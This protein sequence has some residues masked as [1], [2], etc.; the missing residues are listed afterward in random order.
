MRVSA[1]LV[2]ILEASCFG[3][4]VLPSSGTAQQPLIVQGSQPTTLDS[5][6]NVHRYVIVGDSVPGTLN[7]QGG[8]TELIS[9]GPVQF[10]QLPGNVYVGRGAL[11]I[12]NFSGG[13][14]RTGTNGDGETGSIF[15]GDRRGSFG[16]SGEGI[17]NIEPSGPGTVI[18]GGN[19]GTGGSGGAGTGTTGD[20]AGQ[21][22]AF[23][24]HVGN[25]G[26]G[27]VNLSGTAEA[28]NVFIGRASHL[29]TGEFAEGDR[30]VVNVS[31]A[32][33]RLGPRDADTST[34]NIENGY[35]EL[36]VE[37]SGQVNA[38]TLSISGS[39]PDGGI[40]GTV[41]V[42]GGGAGGLP[43]SHINVLETT[44]VADGGGQTT[45]LLE[46]LDGGRFTT[47][48]LSTGG[49]SHAGE[50]RILVDGAGS[51]LD[52]LG[53]TSGSTEVAPQTNIGT[54]SRV[55]GVLQV[56]NGAEADLGV[57]RISRFNNDLGGEVTVAGLGSSIVADSLSIGNASIGIDSIVTARD[58][59]TLTV[60]GDTILN[61]SGQLEIGE[62]GRFINNGTFFS[63]GEF[64]YSGGT[65]GG[66][67]TFLDQLIFGDGQILAPG[68]SPGI[69][70]F[71]AG[72]EWAAGGTYEWELF[73]PAG[74]AGVG[75]DFVDVTGGFGI[76]ASSA[77]PF[78]IDILS[79][80]DPAGDP[81]G[82][83]DAT[84]DYSWTILSADTFTTG[85][86]PSA[87]SLRTAGFGHDLRGG[88]FSFDR[89]GNDLQ[90]SFTASSVASTVPEPGSL[91]LL[92]LGAA[93]LGIGRRFRRRG[94]IERSTRP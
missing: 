27:T 69:M 94:R 63:S 28:R 11:G 53:F 90:V 22:Q 93:G 84:R 14:L 60:N 25:F 46:V 23:N 9:Q 17:F 81:L 87:F 59:G 4:V 75:W 8:L 35:G 10:N 72:L 3:L 52:V 86:D 12:L 37:Q 78:V 39:S 48:T 62:G 89:S 43:A 1:G 61:P 73:D 71:H 82:T 42:T 6:I 7:V 79:G 33:G 57:T 65:L 34:M 19:G 36:N 83:F 91:A 44:R 54:S 26:P 67:G 24:L 88:A 16:P 21:V 80:F 31:G 58:G 64:I 51:R 20:I 40:G 70:E 13:A 38:Q 15:I 29:S 77:D 92:A 32:F 66:S 85:F 50:G 49:G 74:V 18:P 30:G 41:R 5:G 45:G 56:L 47:G 68:N 2:V 76:T 55:A